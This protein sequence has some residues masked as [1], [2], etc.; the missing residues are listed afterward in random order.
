MAK[1]HERT[2]GS[3]FEEAPPRDD[4]TFKEESSEVR[5]QLSQVAPRPEP[6][7]QDTPRQVTRRRS[8]RVLKQEPAHVLNSPA[9]QSALEPLE[10]RR[11]VRIANKAKEA[12][13]L[14]EGA[15][16]SDSR[17]RLLHAALLRQD[18]ALLD[19]L[20]EELKKS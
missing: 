8:E 17:A 9:P 11:S 1:P 2:P 14:L 10:S 5:S 18:E 3:G 20:L 16:S 19:G 6:P 4:P 13:R 12:R 7:R 15:A